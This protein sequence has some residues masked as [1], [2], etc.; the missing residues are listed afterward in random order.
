M[1]SRIGLSLVSNRALIINAI[2][3]QVVWFICVQGTSLFAVLATLVLII[4][5]Q[6]SFK[7]RPKIWKLLI[8]FSLI[9]Y[10]GDN[11][12]AAAFKVN[13]AGV[14]LPLFESL[15]SPFWLLALWLSF[16]TTLN[17]SMLWLF[18]KSYITLIVAIFI[19]PFSYFAGITLSGS[20]FT[21]SSDSLLYWLFFLAEG[22]W[23]AILLLSYGS[24]KSSYEAKNV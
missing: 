12:I 10:I 20:T 21:Y 6:Y 13:Y 19:V 7:P 18:N 22:I 16:A 2:S 5:Y 17:H 24:I 4:I 14:A 9:G 8:V 15:T 11:I 23:W 3:F 1:L